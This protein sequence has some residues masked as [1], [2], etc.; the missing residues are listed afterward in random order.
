[1]IGTDNG[2][3]YPEINMRWLTTHIEHAGEHLKYTLNTAPQAET[4]LRRHVCISGSLEIISDD[5][6]LGDPSLLINKGDVW[7]TDR[8]FTSRFL[9]VVSR[10]D[11][12]NFVCAIP[13]EGY[14]VRETIRT[15]LAGDSITISQGCMVAGF[16]EMLLPNGETVTD[17][18][19][20][21]KNSDITI[22]AVSDIKIIELRSIPL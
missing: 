10:E 18:K 5:D 4:Y 8:G 12:T 17:C 19:I 7:L 20:A 11:N 14:K 16:G 13:L 3:E 2:T 1:M 15:V 9:T 22:V 21:L 6:D